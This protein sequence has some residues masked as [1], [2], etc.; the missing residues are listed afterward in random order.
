MA[1]RKSPFFDTATTLGKVV[2]FFGISA[3]AGVLV[4]GLFTPLAAVVG[5]GATTASSV[6]D[7]LPAE[8]E[9]EPMSLPSEVYSA[10]GKLMAKFFEENRIPVKIDDISENMIDAIVSIEDERFYEHHGVDGQ[11]LARIVV[12]NLTSDTTQG[13]ST[14]TQQ[15]VNN[16]LIN[17]GFLRGEKR[18]TY[19]G[20]KTVGD[21]LRE[22]KLAVAAEKQMSKEQILEGYL[23]LVLFSRTT[24]GVEAASKLFFSKSAKDLTVPE[25]ALLAGI[26]QSPGA[27]DPISNPESAK[28]RQNQVL[29]AMYRNDKITKEEYDEYVAAPLKLKY[30]EPKQGCFSANFGPYFC[31]YVRR[32]ILADKTFGKDEAARERLLYRGGLKITTTLDSRLQKMAQKQV[33]KSV[34]IG[35]K[36]GVGAT[37]ISVDPKSG[38]IKAM[39]QNTKFAIDKKR[40]STAVN[41]NV[42]KKWGD[43]GGFQGGSTLKPYVAVAWLESGRTMGTRVNAQRD[44]FPQYDTWKASCADGG[45]IQIL[46]NNGWKVNNAIGNM[47]K[48]MT[49]DYGL[50]WS[51]NTATVNAAKELDLCKITGVMDRVGLHRA[52]NQEGIDPTTPSFLLGAQ[53]IA[54]LSQATGFA[55]FANDGKRCNP[56]AITKVTDAA[57]NS[58]KVPAKKCENVIDSDVVAQLNTTMKRIASDRIAQGAIN[59][60]IA[61][62]TGTNDNESST[63]FVGYSKGLST[64]AWVGRTTDIKSMVGLNING[65]VFRDVWGSI[66]AGPMWTRYMTE[67]GPLYDT[68]AF[69]APQK[70]V[71]ISEPST[72]QDSDSSSDSNDDSDST[73]SQSSNADADNSTRSEQASEAS[74]ES[75]RPANEN[76]GSSQQNSSNNG[77]QSQSD[78]RSNNNRDNNP[79]RSRN[80]D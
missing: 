4:A 71:R 72:R 79:G 45:S 59:F 61:G 37:L 27:H 29:R 19:S 26:V 62:K 9:E 74:S 32:Q 38:D 2:A 76:R 30:S 39:A 47:K 77:N 64:A 50:Y 13:A 41:F 69:T 17:A 8:L 65:V 10:D 66:I 34:P 42:D 80:N 56:R 68:G 35:D 12:H 5:A 60:P 70:K 48:P 43:S 28:N 6:F 16:Q 58:Y 46:D 31:D 40:G 25:A 78:N 23:N 14:L 63:W 51:I 49:M 36:S 67:A 7:E 15:Y 53:P 3:L 75:S 20:T 1:Q 33:E 21:K 24:Y 54:P 57:G 11:G 44:H 22:M 52:D 55:T 73:N 18:L